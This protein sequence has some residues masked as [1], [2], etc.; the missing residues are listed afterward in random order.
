VRTPKALTRAALATLAVLAAAVP[1]AAQSAPV[2]PYRLETGQK[3]RLWSLPEYGAFR[4][5][6]AVVTAADATGLTVVAGDRTELVPFDGLERIEVRRGWRYLRRA[7]VIGLVVGAA[8][9]ALE[10]DGDGEDVARSAALYGAVGAGLGAVTAGAIW[11][12]KWLPVDIDA[13]RPPPEP[14]AARLS[15]TLR[16]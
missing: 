2:H 12:A 11:P 4:R 7:A 6:S 14:P 9:G 15:F 5:T 10:E 13:V 8:A 3:V 1:A 16:F